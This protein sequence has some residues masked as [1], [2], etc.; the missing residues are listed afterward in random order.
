MFTHVL[1]LSEGPSNKHISPQ[2]RPLAL[3]SSFLS[4]D[5]GGTNWLLPER[6]HSAQWQE[7]MASPWHEASPVKELSHHL[8]PLRIALRWSWA[9]VPNGRMLLWHEKTRG[10]FLCMGVYVCLM[11]SGGGAFCFTFFSCCRKG[12]LNYPQCSHWKQKTLNIW[13]VRR[14]FVFQTIKGN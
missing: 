5:S 4:V 1:R 6:Q 10:P 9:K 7:G 8:R 12:E 13:T 11:A 2:G 14:M 3:L